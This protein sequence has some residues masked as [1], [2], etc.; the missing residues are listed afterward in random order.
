MLFWWLQNFTFEKKIDEWKIIYH[1]NAATK[2]YSSIKVLVRFFL[3]FLSS[4]LISLHN[5]CY[6]QKVIGWHCYIH[7]GNLVKLPRNVLKYSFVLNLFFLSFVLG[8]KNGFSLRGHVL[9]TSLDRYNTVTISCLKLH[10][11]ITYYM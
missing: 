5:C 10:L 11:V 4:S 1:L 9:D 3:N 6:I 7:K 2:N 8:I